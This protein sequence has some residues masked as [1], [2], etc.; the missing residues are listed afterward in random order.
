MYILKKIEERTNNT[1]VSFRYFIGFL[2]ERKCSLIDFITN[3]IKA[4]PVYENSSYYPETSGYQPY[5]SL[6][7]AGNTVDKFGLQNQTTHQEQKPEVKKSLFQRIFGSK[8]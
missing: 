4:Y 1:K 6:Q 5:R 2:E 3:L 8:K 7:N